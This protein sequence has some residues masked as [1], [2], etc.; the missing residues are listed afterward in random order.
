MQALARF[1]DDFERAAAYDPD[2]S[3]LTPQTAIKHLMDV[4]DL[5]V[6]EMADTMGTTQG[7]LSEILRERRGVS[8]EMIRRLI[9]RFGVDARVFL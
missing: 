8:K 9:D 2:L 5:N 3:S 7:T 6:T 4:H 1:V